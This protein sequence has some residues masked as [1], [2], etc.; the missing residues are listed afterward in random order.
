M[1]II[2]Q[3]DFVCSNLNDDNALESCHSFELFEN[4]FDEFFDDSMSDSFNDDDSSD[5]NS[6]NFCANANFTFDR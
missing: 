6:F 5:L 1:K 3:F 2:S 4:I